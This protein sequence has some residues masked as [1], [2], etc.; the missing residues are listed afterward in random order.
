MPF[1]CDRVNA[2]VDATVILG[3]DRD[4]ATGRVIMPRLAFEEPK[5]GPLKTA[6]E[7]AKHRREPGR[8][9]VLVVLKVATV[10]LVLTLVGAVVMLATAGGEEPD[11]KSPSVPEIETSR[12]AE[13]PTTTS[14]A[15]ILAPEVRSQT[16]EMSPTAPPPPPPVTEP[17]TLPAEPPPGQTNQFVRVGEPCDTPGAYAFTES[18]EPVICDGG[19]QNPRLVWRPMFR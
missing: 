2:P 4:R 12:P 16:G 13:T 15:A 8:D 17:T 3:P 7:P 18:F 5:G 1:K 19:R 10:A 9:R 14:P 6:E 11:A